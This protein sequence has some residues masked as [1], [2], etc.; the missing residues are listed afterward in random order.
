VKVKWL[1]HA[2]FLITSGGGVKIITDPY[3]V[4]MGLSYG[5][6]TET[7]DVVLIS[8]DHADHSNAGA[9]KGNPRVIKGAGDK[10]VKGLRF[11]GI[12]TYHDDAGGSKRGVNTVFVFD[13]DGVKVCHLGDLGHDLG[14]KDVSDIGRVDVLLI[15]VG[16]LY[17]IDARVA[18]S[19]S[20]RLTPRTIIP[21]HYATSKVDTSKFGAISGVDDFIK[22]KAGVDRLNASETA[23]ETGK[24]PASTKIVVLKPAL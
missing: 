6:I 12:A 22:G 1:G 10:E 5:E 15:P 24:F 8:H 18:T 2:S 16:G 11:K 23:F 3:K 4:D 9:V 7:A 14:L 20:A 19:L 17:T 13:V 21:M